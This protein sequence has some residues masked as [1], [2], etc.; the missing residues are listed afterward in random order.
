[1]VAR[2]V[3]GGGKNENGL[4]LKPQYMLLCADVAKILSAGLSRVWPEEIEEVAGD[5]A[6][7]TDLSDLKALKGGDSNLGKVCVHGMAMI[8]PSPQ[9]TSSRADEHHL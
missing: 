1:M 6:G 2:L 7:D 8:P 3:E 5:A 4:S 9:V